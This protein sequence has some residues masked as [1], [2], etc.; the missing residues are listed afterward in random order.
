M[1]Q[2]IGSLGTPR[3]VTDMTFD[4]FGETIRVHPHATDLALI[5]FMQSAST[6]DA[7]NVHESMA[8]MVEFLRQQIHPED[9]DRFYATAK[10]N[11]QNVGDLMGVAR[12]ITEAV[13]GFPTGQPSASRHERRQ[14]K[15]GKKSKGGSRSQGGDRPQ[16]TVH[17]AVPA[18]TPQRALTL[19]QGRPDLQMAVVDR[20]NANVAAG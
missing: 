4:Y 16:G 7:A 13:A 17:S 10:A 20:H 18:S 9:W 5:D 1:T 2:H 12:G 6:V 3:S 8:A 14:K 19:L 11:G 15:S